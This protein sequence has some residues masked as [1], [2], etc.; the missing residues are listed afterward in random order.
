MIFTSLSPNTEPDDVGLAAKLLCQPHKWQ[1]GNASSELERKIKNYLPSRFAI[2]TNNGRTALFTILKALAVG[3]GDEILI[4][5]YTCVAV[6]EPVLWLGAKPIFVDCETETLG[7]DPKDLERKITLRSKAIIVQHTFGNPAKID[8]LLTIARKHNLVV[9]E[10]CA[11]ALGAT[12]NGKKVGT[13]GDVSFF[14]FGRDKVISS[15]FGGMIATNNSDLAK[16]MEAIVAEFPYPSKTW[17]VR[18]LLHPLILTGAKATYTFLSLGKVI[19]LVARKTSL[20]SVAVEKIELR[21]GKPSFAF[22]KMP[23]ALALLVLHQFEKLER[24]NNHR[25]KITDIYYRE[26]QS[27]VYMIPKNQHSIYLRFL[28]FIQNPSRLVAL[29]KTRHLE[30]GNWYTEPIAPKN[31]ELEKI[32]YTSCPVAENSA[33]QSCN[34][35]TNIQI[36]EADAIKISNIVKEFMSHG[37]TT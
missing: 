29:A 4:Q 13:F 12:Y 18:Q 9:I 6:P 15:V 35:P 7:M 22:K 34:L 1:K 26:L 23:N 3:S 28:I 10:D 36:S 8:E 24:Y 11:H 21:G 14:S 16:K 27:V 5:A 37:H 17:I 31:V 32:G 19:M 20:I 25:Q 30:L 2:S 33:S